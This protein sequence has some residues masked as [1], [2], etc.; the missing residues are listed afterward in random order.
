MKLGELK[1]WYSRYKD[2]WPQWKDYKNNG[3]STRDII[4][5]EIFRNNNFK[6]NTSM[7]ERFYERKHIS[8][9]LIE[10]LIIKLADNYTTYKEW[11]SQWFQ[12]S[13]VKHASSYGILKFFE[14]PIDYLPLREREKKSLKLFNCQTIREMIEKYDEIDYI[15]DPVFTSILKC[16]NLMI[17]APN[18]EMFVLDE[19]LFGGAKI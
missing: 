13:L 11:V 15:N 7:L 10:P 4:A 14:L 1:E 3:L 9:H 12:L 19:V 2:F 6:I 8:E 5:I 16:K 18:K 17:N